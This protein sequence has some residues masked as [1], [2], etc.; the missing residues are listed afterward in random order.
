MESEGYARPD[1]P[2]CIVFQIQPHMPCTH[3]DPCQ[4]SSLPGKYDSVLLPYKGGQYHAMATLPAEGVDVAEVL[5]ILQA[6][7]GDVVVG[8]G[9]GGGRSGEGWGGITWT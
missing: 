3:Y 4:V 8:V 2:T 5:D 1:D 7:S 6:G 9:S